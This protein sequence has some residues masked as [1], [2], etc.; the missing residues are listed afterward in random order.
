MY[1]FGVRKLKQ[2]GC[3][4]Y[5]VIHMFKLVNLHLASIQVSVTQPVQLNK[6]AIEL[7]HLQN[8]CLLGY[9]IASNVNLLPTFRDNVQTSVKD[10]H[11]AL[12]NT[13]EERRSHQ[14]RGGSLKS[15]N[16]YS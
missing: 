1:T 15:R 12:R 14:H 10:Y 16:I 11:S 8:C 4:A 7:E 2:H 3:K 9:Y 5:V 13:S 6:Q